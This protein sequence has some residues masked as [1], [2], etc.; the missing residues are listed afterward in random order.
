MSDKE[1]VP[2]W[3]DLMKRRGWLFIPDCM[4][5][6][7]WQGIQANPNWQIVIDAIERLPHKDGCDI[8]GCSWLFE[9]LSDK[10]GA[11]EYL[12]EITEDDNGKVIAVR[13]ERFTLSPLKE[14]IDE[15][16]LLDTIQTNIGTLEVYAGAMPKTPDAPKKPRFN[17][18]PLT[19]DDFMKV[20]ADDGWQEG[21]LSVHNSPTPEAPV[22]L[23]EEDQRPEQPTDISGILNTI[24]ACKDA[25]AKDRMVGELAESLGMRDYAGIKLPNPSDQPNEDFRLDCAKTAQDRLAKHLGIAVALDDVE[26]MD[27]ILGVDKQAPAPKTESLAEALAAANRKVGC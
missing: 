13:A 19:K 7:F 5:Q 2:E 9:P 15:S 16:M 8:S 6:T 3:D 22:D 23:S 4:M 27:D 25:F 21:T 26:T 10:E 18:P 14:K 1:A 17:V 24:Q 20:I 11:P 12:V